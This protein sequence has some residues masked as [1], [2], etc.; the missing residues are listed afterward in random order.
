M[1]VLYGDATGIADIYQSGPLRI[2]VGAV[3]IPQPPDPELLPI[4]IA[5]AVDGALAGDGKAVDMVG[6]DESGKILAGL[7]FETSRQHGKVGNAV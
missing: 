6:I 1:H 7:T 4:G 5:V 3:G 2:L